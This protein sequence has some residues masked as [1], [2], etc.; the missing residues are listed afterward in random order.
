MCE[1]LMIKKPTARRRHDH[2][3]FFST[4]QITTIPEQPSRPG[5]SLLSAWA[6]RSISS[7]SAEVRAQKAAAISSVFWNQKLRSTSD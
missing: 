3:H 6:V 2:V 5:A 4:L 1:I 7:L